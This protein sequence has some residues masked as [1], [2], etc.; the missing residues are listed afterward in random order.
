MTATDL[1]HDEI[2]NAEKYLGY[3]SR[4]IL[5]V[6]QN[7]PD[8]YTI[9]S[10]DF[11]GRLSIS[12][13]YA[14]ATDESTD[15]IDIRFGYRALADGDFALV[16]WLPDLFEKS[17]AHID[18][19]RSFQM[20]HPNWDTGPD[21]RFAKWVKRYIQG[22]WAIDNGLIHRLS[23]HIELINAITM[24]LVNI[25]LYSHEISGH[26]RHPVTNNTHAYQDAHRELYGYLLDGINKT[27]IEKTIRSIRENASSEQQ[28]NEGCSHCTIAI[29]Q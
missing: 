24:E 7:S 2:H 29:A 18:R 10:D 19:W 22:S 16:V 26:L 12:D 5:S 6:Y 4:D 8:K 14:E 27:C 21:S 13:T 23:W 9:K 25:P 1:T 28:K 17:K 20:D 11:H 3:F 15:W